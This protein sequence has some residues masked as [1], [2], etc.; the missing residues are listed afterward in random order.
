M[1]IRKSLILDDCVKLPVDSFTH[2]SE[3]HGTVS[4]LDHCLTTHTGYENVKNIEICK[5]CVTDS[6][7]PLFVTVDCSVNVFAKLF[8]VNTLK[9]SFKL[10]TD[11]DIT[12]YNIATERLLSETDIP[13]V[14]LLCDDC[15]C[16]NERHLQEISMF[17]NNIIQD[18]KQLL[19]IVYPA[20]NHIVANKF[21]VG[22]NMSRMVTP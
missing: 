8:N 14:S 3:A 2:V 15:N 1:C 5:D 11:E 9:F 16:S 4:W 12:K 7:L 6:H 13:Y 17:Y 22:M 19:L 20:L 10:N 21:Q 18:F